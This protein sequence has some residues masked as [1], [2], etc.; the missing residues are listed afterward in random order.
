MQNHG[1]HGVHGGHEPGEP[2]LGWS[3]GRLLEQD[4]GELAVVDVPRFD[5]ARGRGLEH[6]VHLVVLRKMAAFV[7]LIDRDAR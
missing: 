1:A 3:P 4:L 6:L 2:G 7:G 5:L